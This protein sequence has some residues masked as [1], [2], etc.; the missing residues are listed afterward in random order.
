MYLVTPEQMKYLEKRS[1]SESFSYGELM[2]NAGRALA[3]VI[4]GLGTEKSIVFLCG[5]GNN[6][7]DCFVAARHLLAY[8]WRVTLAMLCGE[9]K[10][11]ISRAAFSKVKGAEIISDNREIINAVKSA[12]ITAD[13]VFGTGVHG[14]LPKNI[15]EVFSCIG[16]LK[17]AVDV[18]SGGNCLTGQISDGV[19]DADLTVTF[20]YE[21]FGMEQYP[22][23]AKCDRIIIVD[24]GISK[25][26]MNEL[27]TPIV[28]TDDNLVKSFIKRR[29]PDSHKG[30]FG[31]L[32]CVTGSLKMP[33]A[34]IMAAKAALRCGCGLLVSA[35]CNE[36]I[37]TLCSHMCESMFEPMITDSNGF[38]TSEN[39]ERLMMHAETSSALLIGCGIGVTEETKK[40]VRL[41]LKNVS[42][43]IILDADGIN[44]IGSSIDIIREAKPEVI[45]TP[46]PAEM[47]R[48]SG[49]NT[50]DVQRDRLGISLDYSRKSGAVT[51]LKGA[52][53]VIAAGSRAYVNPTGNPGMSRGGSGDVLSGMTASFVAQGIS[54]EYSAVLAAYFHGKAGDKAAE[55]LSCQAMLPTDMIDMLPEVF[56]EMGY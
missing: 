24:I 4:R 37:P 11:E 49:V 23:R 21:K 46:H 31:K 7:G 38:Y 44:C 15:A 54:P 41:L 51:V 20:A 33:G 47:A 28:L 22:L 45:V 19:I 26:Y 1:D 5:S 16:G 56:K 3:D 40:L 18:P 42:C 52:G 13:G 14:E 9:P 34:G 32:L 55:R 17:L 50:A 43:P 53:T 27:D 30:N 2:E 39:Y 12:P 48:L 25:N 10:T 6:A 36:N 35:C 29:K 8:G